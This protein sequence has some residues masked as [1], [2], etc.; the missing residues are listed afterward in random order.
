MIVRRRMSSYQWLHVQ[1]DFSPAAIIRQTNS[2]GR[3]KSCDKHHN[4]Q[5]R[6]ESQVTLSGT[7]FNTTRLWISQSQQQQRLN[8]FRQVDAMKRPGWRSKRPS[9]CGRKRTELVDLTPLNQC[10][11]LEC[12]CVFECVCECVWRCLTPASQRRRWWIGRVYS[13][14]FFITERNKKEKE[15]T[16]F[17]FLSRL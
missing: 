10:V 3:Q 9:E 7:V 6:V 14:T 16:F 17:F 4:H 12:V 15:T 5:N 2:E 1:V 13:D 11:S 8:A